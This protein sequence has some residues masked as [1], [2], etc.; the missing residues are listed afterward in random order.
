MSRS[1]RRTVR[2]LTGPVLAL[3]AMLAVSRMGRGPAQG[4]S[5]AGASAEAAPPRGH[6][7][8]NPAEIPPAGWREIGVRAAKAFMAD[9]LMLIAAGVTFYALLATFPAITAL[10]SVY[11]LFTDPAEVGGH[12]NAM[13]GILPGGAMEIMGAQ[14]ERVAAHGGGALGLGLVI[15]LTLALWSA[16]AGMK[17]L[18]SALNIVYGEAESRGFV[19]LTALTLLFTAGM[20]AF[21]VLALGAVIALP[22]ALNI[23]GLAQTERWLLW[24]RWPALLIAVA[25]AL[26]VIYRYG[27][28][29]TNARWVWITPGGLLAGAAWLGVSAGFS[30]YVENFGSYDETY[31][32]LGA[33]VGFMTWIWIS[34]MIILFGATVNAQAERQT[35]MD[36]TVPPSVPM[37]ERGAAAA[38]SHAGET[39]NLTRR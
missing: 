36:T 39:A 31:G 22:A 30:W 8:R 9:R 28:S 23:L 29:R 25:I 3:G 10:V 7:A 1:R 37:G 20:I 35:V 32:S 2:G 21:V 16:N 13:A 27:P 26:S 33:A 24:L 6:L 38:D 17:N 34:A 18:F 11:G 15:G 4:P 12:L 14:M 5:R 19:T